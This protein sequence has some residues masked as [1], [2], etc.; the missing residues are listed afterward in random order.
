MKKIIDNSTEN[1]LGFDILSE[2]EMM[3]VRGGGDTRP[4]VRDIDIF[5]EGAE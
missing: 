2:D 1:F 4:R 3:Q 5:D